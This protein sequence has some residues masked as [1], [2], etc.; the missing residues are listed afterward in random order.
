MAILDVLSV[1]GSSNPAPHTYALTYWGA[2]A[3]APALYC[4]VLLHYIGSLGWGGLGQGQMAEMQL[5]VV[6]YPT[7]KI[8]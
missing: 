3:P 1:R 4:T 7:D 5:L 2:P 6:V 8:D